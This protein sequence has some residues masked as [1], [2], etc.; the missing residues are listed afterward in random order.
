MTSALSIAVVLALYVGATKLHAARPSF[1]TLPVLT[2]P[3]AIAIIVAVAHLDGARVD[4]ATAPLTWMLGPATTAF[5]LPIYQ[6]RARIRRF[7]V[8]IAIG[9][10]AGAIGAL[11][12][13]AAAARVLHLAPAVVASLLPK[14]VTTPIALPLCDR[15]GGTAP[16]TVAAVLV[17]GTLGMA[18][19][20]EL[21]TKLGVVDATARGLAMGTAAHGFGTARAIREGEV[22]GAMSGV[23]MIVAGVVTALVL[24]LWTLR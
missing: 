3:L 11:V 13:I 15:L 12:F 18:Y 20:P 22:T 4:A 1:F 23:A 2:A 10:S 14:S 8:P 24:S 16:L 19:G 17:S 6:Q 5:A 9:V 7:A 21:L